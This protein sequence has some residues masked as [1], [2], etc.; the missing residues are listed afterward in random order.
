MAA[1]LILFCNIL[2]VVFLPILVKL[3]VESQPVKSWI[4]EKD[5]QK[6]APYFLHISWTAT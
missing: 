2:K 6:V 1:H 5:M 4:T 3:E